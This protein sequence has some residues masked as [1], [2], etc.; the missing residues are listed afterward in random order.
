MQAPLELIWLVAYLPCLVSSSKLPV[1]CLFRIISSLVVEFSFLNRPML[2]KAKILPSHAFLEDKYHVLLYCSRD[3]SWKLGQKFTQVLF[4]TD[5]WYPGKYT[6]RRVD[7]FSSMIRKSPWFEA[8]WDRDLI[9]FSPLL[10]LPLSP[11][12]ASHMSGD[13]GYPVKTV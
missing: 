11:L 4:Y 13:K 8:H 6:Q 1:D 12:T 5:W 7:T 10:P 3:F 9:S 2:Q